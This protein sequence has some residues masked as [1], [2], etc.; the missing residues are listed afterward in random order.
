M[1]SRAHGAH[2][3]RR[4]TQGLGLE[5][6]MDYRVERGLW[7]TCA[8]AG[9]RLWEVLDASYSLE[10]AA[11]C[12]SRACGQ[13]DV[14]AVVWQTFHRGSEAVALE[15]GHWRQLRLDLVL[16]GFEKCGTSSVSHNLARHPQRFCGPP[17]RSRRRR[18]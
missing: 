18:A 5:G 7:D 9:G 16:A 8:S 11:L 15:L 13:R 4:S 14:E 2:V 17:R 12:A 3:A 6:S 10:G 1:E